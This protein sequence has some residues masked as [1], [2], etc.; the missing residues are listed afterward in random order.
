MKK[1]GI[2][3]FHRASNYG[4]VLQAYALQ[5]VLQRLG[6]DV[7]IIDYRCNTVEKA[8]T[9][10][11]FLKDKKVK[12]LLRLPRK[13][14]KY[15]LF[16]AFRKRK[17]NLTEPVNRKTIT[18]TASDLDAVIAG[19]DQLWCEKFSGMDPVYFMNFF[20]GK[21]CYTYAVSAGD[22]LDS[23]KFRDTL[24]K[25][26]NSIKAISLRESSSVEPVQ[27][28]VGK[29][30]R[31]DLDPTFLLT[32][33]EWIREA[34]LPDHGRPYVLIYTV[35]APVHLIEKAKLYAEK[36]GFDLIYLHN[37][38]EK[39]KGIKKVQNASPEEFVGWFANAECVFTNSFHGTA[40]SINLQKDF[41]IEAE[42]N[43]GKNQ[44][45]MDLISLLEIRD[46][47]IEK[48]WSH[49]G[50]DEWE[51]VDR[52]LTDLRNRSM[53]YLKMISRNDR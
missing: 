28:I 53:D 50:E 11:P 13:A 8:H 23:P 9:P 17:L 1:I 3:T 15:R 40:F 7:R 22:N 2:L 35:A 46:R 33:D 31:V 26:S 45:S 19:S 47:Q 14:S 18:E 52:L 51:R 38:R 44:R 27:A 30:C 10:G 4:A 5:T 25:Y 48:N 12:G 34:A 42:S 43:R 20:R 6:A 37:G 39:Y 16:D 49:I 41:Y 21:G 29:E 32:K 36:N 24:K